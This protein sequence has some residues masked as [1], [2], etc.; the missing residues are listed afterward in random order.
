MVAGAALGQ[1][2]NPEDALSAGDGSGPLSDVSTNVGD[3]SRAVHDGAQTIGETSAGSVRSA[4]PVSG[5]GS[6][7]ML[8][9]P[10]SSLSRG[11]MSE[12][13]PPL[14]GGSM[15]EASAG[16]VKQ[17]SS[18]GLGTRIS[19]PLRELG[20]LQEQ[21]RARRQQAEQAAVQAATEPAVPPI[22]A[23]APIEPAAIAEPEASVP[24]EVPPVP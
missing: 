14:S 22:E 2:R 7:S 24:Q 3:G 16:T 1:V 13:R 5:A 10:V 6:R 18:H 21:M 9:G 4:G 23:F 20:P 15:T 8:S 17:D 11:P 12:P 19:D